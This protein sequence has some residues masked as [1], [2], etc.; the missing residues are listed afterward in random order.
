MVLVFISATL[1]IIALILT[2]SNKEIKRMEEANKRRG[3]ML[4]NIIE[5]LEK[6]QKEHEKG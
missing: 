2:P 3:E 4:D 5:R 1:A 6:L